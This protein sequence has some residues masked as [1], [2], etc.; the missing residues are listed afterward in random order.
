[1]FEN[2][3]EHY[4]NFCN[5]KEALYYC[6]NC[7]LIFC[8]S[9]ADKEIRYLI[10]CSNCFS[11][12]QEFE[13]TEDI[14][15]KSF[16]CPEC[17][18]VKHKE[19]T[20]N[21]KL[22]PSC[23]SHDILTIAEKKRNLIKSIR[24]SAVLLRQGYE[25]LNSFINR[26]EKV[27]SSLYKLRINGYLHEFTIEKILFELYSQI[28]IIKDKLFLKVRQDYELLKNQLANVSNLKNWVPHNFPSIESTIT[29]VIETARSHSKFVTDTFNPLNKQ[30]AIINSKI[31]AINYFKN[32]FDEYQNNLLLL[33]G[34]LPVCAFKE[35]KFNKFSN[36]EIKSKKGTLFFTDRRIIFYMKKGFFFKKLF[37]HFDLIY[38]GFEKACI[39]GRFFKKIYISVD[40]GELIFSA[41]PN[42]LNAILK[43]FNVAI[44]FEKYR[45]SDKVSPRIFDKK[46]FELM[47]LKNS[48]ETCITNLLNFQNMRPQIIENQIQ[49]RRP[50]FQS[51][52]NQNQGFRR[53]ATINNTFEDFNEPKESDMNNFFEG[54]NTPIEPFQTGNIFDGYETPTEPIQSRNVYS[55]I[56]QPIQSREEN[57]AINKDQIVLKLERERFIVEN[58]ISSLEDKYHKGFISSED[59]LRYY[60]INQEKLFRITEQLEELNKDQVNRSHYNQILSFRH[61]H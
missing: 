51:I 19:A 55:G 47:D 9:C 5:E 36:E 18:S 52:K 4:C 41:K 24:D 1:M 35:I 32:I 40:M 10:I 37:K 23:R 48:I 61:S 31:E 11:S 42:L 49:F 57:F 29:Q 33:P 30:I 46:E 53:Q 26:T 28:P 12:I 39:K 45:V 58:T 22:C 44:N 3:F 20:K 13:F 34:E 2:K 8:N 43:Y 54:Y 25:K 21:I 60:K 56:N 27:K 14:K 59:F 17:K 6:N 50:V 7:S 16:K 38:E 15:E